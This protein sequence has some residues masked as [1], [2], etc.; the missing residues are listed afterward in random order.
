MSTPIQYLSI[1]E[2]LLQSEG[3]LLLDVRAP[4]EYNKGH[5]PHATSFPL[6]NDEER[7]VVGTAYKQKGKAQ[8]IEIGLDIVG[9]KMGDFARSL[10]TLTVEKK[11][12][13]HCWRGGMRSGALAWLINL[14]GYEVYVLQ[15]G[16]KAY[17]QKVLDDLATPLKLCVIG[18]ETG[19]GKTE[20]LYALQNTGEQII[21]LE[22]IANHK[23]SAFGGLGQSPQPKPEQF[24]NNL[25]LAVSRIDCNKTCWLEDESKSLGTCYIPEPFWVQLKAAPVFKIHLPN[26]RRIRHL[27]NQYASFPIETLSDCIRPLAKRMGTESMNNALE[28]L[29]Q[30]QLEEVAK[31][32]LRYYDKAYHFSATKKQ[33]PIAQDLLFDKQSYPEIAAILIQKTKT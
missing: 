23:G 4:K 12:F 9:K 1:H 10:R 22:R 18:G 15:G 14:L 32:M 8:A 26:E 11:V 5:I 21:D 7:A 20:I 13:I 33:H 6:F 16:Y 31:I 24:E 17:R 28:A 30:N 19:S 27:M 29:Q 25:H 2:F 3:Y